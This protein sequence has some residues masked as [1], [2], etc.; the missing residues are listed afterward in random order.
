MMLIFAKFSNEK[1]SEISEIDSIYCNWATFK[2]KRM[3]INKF[4]IDS[5]P[6]SFQ[7]FTLRTQAS[8][9]DE[10]ILNEP[11]QMR[12]NLS[13]CLQCQSAF[14]RLL[15]ILQAQK[16]LK[17]EAC[18]S[19]FKFILRQFICIR[20]IQNELCRCVSRPMICCGR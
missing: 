11:C 6:Q 1:L 17:H 13:V 12:S 18:Q 16:V 5:R 10:W 4:S 19:K 8:K 9:H 14:F 2:T 3:H 20:K 7:I 15:L